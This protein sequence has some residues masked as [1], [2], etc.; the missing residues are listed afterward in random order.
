[1]KS[2]DY[3]DP[4]NY[5]YFERT[6]VHRRCNRTAILRAQSLELFEVAFPNGETSSCPITGCG[7]GMPNE[8]FEFIS[9]TK[10]IDSYEQVLEELRS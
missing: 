8:E 1:M 7:L 10:R 3:N 4:N 9:D 2:F 5:P 6:F